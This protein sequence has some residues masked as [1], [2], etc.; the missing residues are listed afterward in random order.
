MSKRGVGIKTIIGSVLWA[1]VSQNLAAEE[2]P[3]ANG[4]AA[5]LLVTVESRHGS[6]VPAVSRK[7]LTVYE[8]R[9]SLQS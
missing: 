8:G 6:N 9:G 4:V 1:S 2:A 7:D 3:A 5:H